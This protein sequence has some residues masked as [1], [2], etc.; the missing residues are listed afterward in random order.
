MKVLSDKAKIESQSLAFA[1]LPDDLN[2]SALVHCSKALV[3]KPS[4]RMA[5]AKLCKIFG[6]VTQ[7]LHYFTTIL[8]QIKLFTE[9]KNADIVKSLNTL[10]NYFVVKMSFC[11]FC[12]KLIAQGQK[13]S[14][15][16]IFHR[17]HQLHAIYTSSSKWS[18]GFLF[19]KS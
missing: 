18:R 9:P 19:L 14:L 1:M 6:F 11:L 7:N 15:T 8:Q 13:T 5:E 16:T 10:M 17:L 4:G 12:F 3:I 2:T